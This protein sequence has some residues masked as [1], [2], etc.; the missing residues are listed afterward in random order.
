MI[1][2]SFCRGLKN[3]MDQIDG[4]VPYLLPTQQ[5]KRCRKKHNKQCAIHSQMDGD[6]KDRISILGM[7]IC[8]AIWTW[9]CRGILTKRQGRWK[10]YGHS[11]P[12]PYGEFSKTYQHRVGF[13]SSE[14][15]FTSDG[16]KA[17]F[18]H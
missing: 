3:K 13:G 17:M 15:K 6:S 11:M 8:Y 5:Q 18:R 12:L 4:D 1:Q 10:P 14:P 16:V 9:I 7:S 2:Q